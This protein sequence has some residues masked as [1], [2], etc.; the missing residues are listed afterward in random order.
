MNHLVDVL[1]KTEA[2]L[3]D[4]GVASP[5]LDAEL[6]LG[7][8]LGLDRVQLYL[9]FDRPLDEAELAP[10]REHVKR[11]GDREPL[12][13]VLGTK[14]FYT[15][16]LAAHKGVLV[17]RSDTETL[18]ESALARIPEEGE[19]FVVDVGCGTGAVGLS[20]ASER[21]GVK[22]FAT[23]I[24]DAALRCTRE[25]V[26]RLSLGDRVAVLKGPLLEPIPPERPIDIVVSNPPYIPSADIDGLEPEI[27][28]HEPRAALDGGP[29]GLD[30]YR[31]LIPAAA[32]RARVAVLV[33]VG[34]GQA[35]AVSALMV[36]AGLGSIQVHQDLA[37]HGRVVEGALQ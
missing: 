16:T 22:L 17:P 30:I 3:R 34:A 14:D 9:Q 26:K 11:R 29:D 24:S 19:C 18:V 36:Q 1:K 25:N 35:E 8:H 10:M 4:K 15:L 7:H 37:G 2:Y 21:A 12:A 13:W 32:K 6:I 23:D 27:S 28:R 31:K 33:E 5:R 20:L